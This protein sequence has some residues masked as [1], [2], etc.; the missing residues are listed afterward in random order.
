MRRTI[1][2]AWLAALLGVGLAAGCDRDASR[3]LYPSDPL[4]QSRKPV[5]GGRE[6]T[7]PMLARAEP[8]LPAPPPAALASAPVP[9]RPDGTIGVAAASR[10]SLSATP[11]AR[12]SNPG[13]VPAQPAVRRRPAATYGPNEPSGGPK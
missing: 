5:E 3:Q 8:V 2:Q 4:L 13:G 12:P 10:P 11:A 6:E 1:G 9:L 7:A